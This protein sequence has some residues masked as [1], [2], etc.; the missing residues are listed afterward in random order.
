MTIKSSPQAKPRL[1]VITSMF[2]R[3][4]ND[5]E[6]GFV[7]ELCRQLIARFDVRVLAPHTRHAEPDE[8]MDGVEIVRFRYAPQTFQML[9]YGGGIVPK[10][11]LHPWLWLLVPFFFL[12]QYVA[13]RRQIKAWKPDVIHAHWV[14]P[15]GVVA[16]AAVR[17]PNRARLLVTAHGTDVFAL[18]SRL[19]AWVK[20][21]V[22]RRADAVTVVGAAL[23]DAVVRLGVDPSKVSVEPMGVDLH[24]K[25][26]P[27]PAPLRSNHE[28]L[29]VGRLV[30]SKGIRHLLDAAPLIL[31]QRADVRFLIAG[32]G[33]EEAF[34]KQRSVELGIAF[35]VNF[36]G[37]IAPSELPALYRRAAV[38][39]APFVKTKSG[40]QEGFGLVIVEAIGCECPVV[41]S[42]VAALQ[43]LLGATQTT[44]APGDVE[45]LA[46]AVLRVLKEPSIAAVRAQTL[47]QRVCD[48]FDWTAVGARYA[49]L[50]LGD[51]ASPEK[52]GSVS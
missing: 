31:A 5:A 13:L 28:V 40:A 43:E 33:P 50:L 10:L 41:V 26:V 47:R 1:L 44:V 23:R 7:F 39:V 35:A 16:A 51:A 18:N 27:G 17:G 15:Q 36:L 49:K 37:P 8:I 14:I 3:W 30:E 6:P 25:F 32:F 45:G 38:F 12:G 11:K 34:L 52:R 22:L 20:R 24:G 4:P 21:V 9:A 42:G 19:L 46:N 2:P 48:R 29:F